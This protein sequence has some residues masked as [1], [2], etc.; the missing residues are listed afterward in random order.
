MGQLGKHLVHARVALIQELTQAYADEWFAQY[1][2]W[3]VVHTLSGPAA[4]VTRLEKKVGLTN[5]R[6][7]AGVRIVPVP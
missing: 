1:N 7:V 5:I 3:F 2:Y 4:R 6:S